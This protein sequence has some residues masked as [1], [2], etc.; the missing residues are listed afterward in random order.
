MCVCVCGG[1]GGLAGHVRLVPVCVCAKMNATMYQEA[2][3]R[4]CVYFNPQH[5]GMHTKILL[6]S[7]KSGRGLGTMPN[8]RKCYRKSLV[9]VFHNGGLKA[10]LNTKV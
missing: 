6:C 5:A 2:G 10:A 3:A 8:T 7:Q 1:G 4:R 9:L